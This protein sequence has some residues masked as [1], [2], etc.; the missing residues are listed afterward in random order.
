MVSLQAKA[1]KNKWT[2]RLV[3]IVCRGLTKE[4]HRITNQRRLL[5]L[6]SVVAIVTLV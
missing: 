4:H 6:L 2:I 5:R 3:Q 1:L